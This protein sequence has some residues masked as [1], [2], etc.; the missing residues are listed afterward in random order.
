[1]KLSK[2]PK[3]IWWFVVLPLVLFGL[4]IWQ[5]WPE[6]EK[7]RGEDERGAITALNNLYLSY[8]PP[9]PPYEV[10]YLPAIVQ[11]AISQGEIES[12][13]ETPSHGYSFLAIRNASSPKGNTQ[14]P[15][16]HVFCAYPATY[17]WRHRRTFITNQFPRIFS[18]D[19][20]GDPVTEWPTDEELAERFSMVERD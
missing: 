9:G 7:Y 5:W 18:I 17:D 14:S 13:T 10:I 6:F 4:G 3:H 11:H 16:Q 15:G 12:P 8:Y 19:N 2:I 20:G 1:M